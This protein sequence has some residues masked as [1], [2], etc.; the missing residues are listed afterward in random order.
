MIWLMMCWW[1]TR[2]ATSTDMKILSW[3]C[4]GLRQA[5]TRRALNDLIFKHRPCLVFLME[6]KKKKQYLERLRRKCV[7]SS[8]VY[9]EPQGYSGGLALWWTENVHISIFTFDKNILDGCC[10]DAADSVSWHFS[11]VYREP[12]AQL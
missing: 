6:T 5:L 7:F 2:A 9:V 11:F 8:S 3:N 1:L 12:N 4:Q 10:S